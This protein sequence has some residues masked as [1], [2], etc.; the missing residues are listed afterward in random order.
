M[1][2]R[3]FKSVSQDINLLEEFGFIDLIKENTGG[4]K[5]LR[6]VTVIDILKIEIVL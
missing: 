5:R 1:V 6:P 2:Q 3:D 4:R